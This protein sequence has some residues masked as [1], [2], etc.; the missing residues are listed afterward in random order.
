MGFAWTFDAIGTKWRITSADQP[1]PHHTD[2]S[3]EQAVRQR[4]EAFDKAYSRFRDDSLVM[5]MSRQAGTHQL[6]EDGFK[7]LQFYEQLYVATSGL[8]TPL[9]GQVISDAGY[10]ASYSFSP[11]KLRTPPAWEQVIEGYDQRSIT[12]RTPALLDF[13]AAGKG[14]LIDIIGDMLKA[15]GVEQFMINAGG[16]IL[17]KNIAAGQIG[18]ENPFNGQEVIG[19]VRIQNQSICASAGNKRQWSDY[20]HLIN[21]MTLTSP[22]NITASWAVAPSAMVADGLATALFFTEPAR[23][24]AMFDFSYALLRADMSL[25]YDSSFPLVTVKETV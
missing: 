8:C 10:D 3:L 19:V 18:L 12:L 25:E 2:Q 4:I 9:I 22:Q 24:R 15:A 14:Y 23:L 16:D 20:T 6:P 21:P 17:S 7:L 13:G 1:D 11:G 5:T